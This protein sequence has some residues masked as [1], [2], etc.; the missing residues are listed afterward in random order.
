MSATPSA[1]RAV[2]GSDPHYTVVG[3][4]NRGVLVQSKRLAPFHEDLTKKQPFEPSTVQ[5]GERTRIK[6]DF[7]HSVDRELILNDIRLRFRLSF[8]QRAD[9]GKVF[10]VRATD[11]IRELTVKI[12]E[13][14]VFKTDKYQELTHLWLMNNHRVGGENDETRQS[15]LLNHGVI[16]F[17]D[18]PPLFYRASD[19]TWY[20]SYTPANPSATPPVAE[21][22]SDPVTG[23]WADNGPLSRLRRS[24]LERHDGRPRL[25]YDDAPASRYQFP[26]DVSLNQLVG[27]I[28]NRFHMRRVEYVQ[29]EIVF[30]PW[31][32]PLQTQDFLLF[33]RDP[34]VNGT[35]PHPYSVARFTDLEIVQFR[36]TLLDGVHGFTLAPNRML[37]WLMHR[38]SRREYTFDFDQR[39]SL[40]I[41]LHD[42]EIRTNITRV[43]WM[44]APRNVL[45]N[46]N[47]GNGFN[48]YAAP[49]EPYDDLFAVELRWKNDKVLDL[50]T[51]Q[52]VVR[53]Y[54]L[55]ENKRHGLN[56][57]HVRFE[58]L[59]RSTDMRGEVVDNHVVQY[60]WGVDPA[61]QA[62]WVPAVPGT[63][64]VG[65][66]HYEVPIYHVDLA[67]NIHHGVHGGTIVGG[68][69]NDTSDY[70]VRLKRVVDDHGDTPTAGTYQHTGTRTL[71]V[72][73]EYQTLVNLAAGSNQFN[74]GS[75]TITK[76]L[77]VQN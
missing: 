62:D 42:W 70:V 21:S 28:F 59:I 41:Q 29:I 9:V 19:R 32:S 20:F 44:W 52:D 56:N 68:I 64:M 51:R 37:S 63:G 4:N 24:G 76:Q 17:G 77:N 60:R 39:T 2:T 55:S 48:P 69:V 33:K 14:I 13:D 15:G 7:K 34:T 40:D 6:L 61:T 23:P 46:P 72:W 31:L 71:Y 1:V 75:Q 22:W 10:C 43:Y 54:T 49:C 73:L 45:A 57:P 65:R 16:P 66:L 8:T 74:R 67:M 35:L 58:R 47:S 11:L 25:V 36:T 30:E 3:S 27:S 12:N 26:F 38:F 5:P 53:H 50:V 18:A